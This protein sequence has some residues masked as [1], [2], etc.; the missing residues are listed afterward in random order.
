MCLLSVIINDLISANFA[1]IVGIFAWI[2]TNTIPSNLIRER[3]SM[4][5]GSKILFALFPNMALE[6]GYQAISVYE[7]RELGASWGNL[8]K[9]PSGGTEDITMGNVFIMFIVDI[10]VYVLITLYVE[11]VKP[12]PYGLAKPFHFPISVSFVALKS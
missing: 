6:F 2:L 4:K 7:T 5:W 10:I 8:F 1:M 11:N 3:P 9:S 12:G